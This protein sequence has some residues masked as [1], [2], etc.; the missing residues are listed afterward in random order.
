MTTLAVDD[1]PLIASNTLDDAATV[2]SPVVL[3]AGSMVVGPE[4]PEYLP[5]AT[6]T[7][8]T[9]RRSYLSGSGLSMSSE[10][11]YLAA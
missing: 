10:A 2:R 6:F 4:Q 7:Q 9:Y 5:L 11:P 1:V 3:C 8:H